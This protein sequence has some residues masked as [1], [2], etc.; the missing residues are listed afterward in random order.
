MTRTIFVDVESFYS[1]TITLKGMTLRQYLAA[2]HI[3]GF[4]AAEGDEAPQWFSPSMP[5]WDAACEYLRQASREGAIFVAHNAAFDIRA[6]VHWIALP[7]PQRIRCSLE[8][9]C[10]AYP[11]QPG[12]YKLGSLAKTLNLGADKLAI[13]LQKAHEDELARY[14]IRDVELCRAL[15]YKCIPRLHEDELKIAEM[16]NQLRS[17]R[18]TV[19]SG[20]VRASIASLST[21]AAMHAQ[22]AIDAM[23]SDDGFGRDDDGTVRSVK[24]AKIK[25]ALLDHLGFETQSISFKKINPEKLRSHEQ[26]GIALKAV[27]R[28]N[29]ALS[30]KRRMAV[31]ATA[32]EIDAEL[33]YY[34]AHTGRFSSP[35]V[36]SKGLNL[37]NLP[38][39]DK[40]LSQAIRS[41][42]MLPGDKCFVRADLAN[43]E[44][45]HECWLTNAEAGEMFTADPLTDPYAAFWQRATGQVCSKKVNVPARQLAKAAVL[46][47]GFLMGITRWMEVLL[48]GLSDPSFKVTLADLEAVCRAND[49]HQPVDR[50]VKAA[51]T[52]T[53]A[54]WQVAAVAEQT[55]KRFHAVHPEF[56]RTARWIDTA[57]GMLIRAA[58]PARILDE[59]YQLPTAPDRN[60]IGLVWAGDDY[61]PGTQ[62]VRVVCGDWPAPTVTW[63]DLCMRESTFGGWALHGMHATK[64]YRALS[65]NIFIENITQSSARNAMC[66]AQLKLLAEYP[67]QLTV[68]D[69]LMLIVDR[70]PAAVLKARDDLLATLGPG[71]GS[72]HT[73]IDPSEINVS[74][75]LYETDCSPEWWAQLS[76]NQHDTHQLQEIA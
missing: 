40:N 68:H 9:C 13:N 30:H 1:P 2:S 14:C 32:C 55:H 11:N 56:G 28:T 47:L 38:K 44:Y 50:W 73:L 39:R 58:D 57:I 17:L 24:P 4:A 48:Q 16:C 8:L 53:R 42:F 18:F 64:G 15:Y 7:Y 71:A 10:A 43:V 3:L 29:K 36:G 72:W 76:T 33:G 65:K 59:C 69:E 52:K 61:G 45:R 27:E 62:S 21:T 19:N 51:Q 67:M 70:T 5:E 35:G 66:K 22:S 46:G 34:R 12:G 49:W 20:D 54:P 63:R 41:V 75:S 37:H 25:A 6:L 31:F 74:H 23:G 60:R 26:A